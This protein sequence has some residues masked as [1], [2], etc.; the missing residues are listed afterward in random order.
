MKPPLA[1]TV[2]GVA[3]AAALIAIG[4]MISGCSKQAAPP[5]APAGTQIQT[6]GMSPDDV[7]KSHM[8]QS[9]QGGGGGK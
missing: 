3:F 5:P 6:R 7:V 8:Q 1:S 9:Q 4:L 2:A